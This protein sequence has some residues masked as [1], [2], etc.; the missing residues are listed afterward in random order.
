MVFYCS[1]PTYLL[2]LEPLL[3]FLLLVLTV[4]SGGEGKLVCIIVNSRSN[5]NKKPVHI[6]I[7]NWS[8]LNKK[9][10]YIYI[11]SGSNINMNLKVN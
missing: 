2:E 8:N 7:N 11:N 4:T 6:N 10:V 5:L 1:I 9:P 3:H